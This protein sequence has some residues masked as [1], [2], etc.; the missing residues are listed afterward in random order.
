MF[1]AVGAVLLS[2]WVALLFG[3]AVTHVSYLF[4]VALPPA[5]AIALAIHRGALVQAMGLWWRWRPSWRSLA[6]AA[7]A[8]LWLTLAGAIVSTG[9]LPIALPAAGLAG[10]LNARAYFGIVADIVT[11]RRP[12]SAAR[13]LYVPAALAATFAIVIGGTQVG[14]TATAPRSRM[15]PAS[16]GIPSAAYGHPVLVAAGYGSRWDPHPV[17]RLPDGTVITHSRAILS[18]IATQS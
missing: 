18:W 3:L 11:P 12:L 7:G 14:F 17:L 2:P 8:F 1:Y 9:R 13:R 16:V 5:L 10:L 6:W 15:A 4:F